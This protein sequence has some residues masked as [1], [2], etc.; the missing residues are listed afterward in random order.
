MR[1]ASDGLTDPKLLKLQMQ[2]NSQRREYRLDVATLRYLVTKAG[3]SKAEQREYLQRRRP[4][5][6]PPSR[7]HETN[8]TQ[9]DEIGLGETNAVATLPEGFKSQVAADVVD[10]NKSTKVNETNEA[11]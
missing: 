2:L 11:L 7:R 9:R 5:P 10:A 6:S 3:F 1:P 8:E 4:L